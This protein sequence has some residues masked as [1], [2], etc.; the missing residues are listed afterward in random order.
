LASGLA[1]LT[2][3]EFLT[4]EWSLQPPG[5]KRFLTL[6]LNGSGYESGSKNQTKPNQIKPNQQPGNKQ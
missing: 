3:V 6:L 5:K 2:N 1:Q 4:A